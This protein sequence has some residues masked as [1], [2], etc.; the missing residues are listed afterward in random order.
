MLLKEEEAGAAF[1]QILTGGARGAGDQAE[2]FWFCKI[3]PC[4]PA[5]WR[6]VL[7]V[8]GGATFYPSII[9]KFFCN[10]LFSAL[11]MRKESQI[12]VGGINGF[13]ICLAEIAESS[14]NVTFEQEGP[15][16]G[17][18]KLRYSVHQGYKDGPW[19]EQQQLVEIGIFAAKSCQSWTFCSC[20]WLY[21]VPTVKTQEG[22]KSEIDTH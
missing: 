22:K 5:D 8:G 21:H 4:S 6:S 19:G 17:M 12:I 18:W 11:E 20:P 9:L 13:F 15:N 10:L 3:C 16:L 7:R 1:Q 2:P 14:K